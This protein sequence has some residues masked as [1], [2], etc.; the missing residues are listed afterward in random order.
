MQMDVPN[1]RQDSWRPAPPP[2]YPNMSV[3]L[4][5]GNPRASYVLLTGI[6][7]DSPRL[8]QDGVLEALSGRMGNGG[9][10]AECP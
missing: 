4:P 6:D 1:A 8:P 3:T 5:P 7:G 10:R 2:T 9:T